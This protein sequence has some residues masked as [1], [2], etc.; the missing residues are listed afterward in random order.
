M[1]APV[2]GGI[3]SGFPVVFSDGPLPTLPGA[4]TLGMHNGE[5]YGKLLDLDESD[6]EGLYSGGVI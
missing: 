3:A 5:I 4:P 2:P 6:L 1:D